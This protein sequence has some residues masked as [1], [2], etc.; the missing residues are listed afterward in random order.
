LQNVLVPGLIEFEG[1]LD[2]EVELAIVISQPYFPIIAVGDEEIEEWFSGKGYKKVT[3]AAFYKASENLAVF[4]AHDRNVI[5]FKDT[6][7]PFDVIPCFP[8]MELMTLI[9]Q[10]LERGD[11]VSAQRITQTTSRASGL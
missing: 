9:Q 10:A 7:I 6:L 2:L 5:R 8:D 4:D 3:H 11:A 1:V